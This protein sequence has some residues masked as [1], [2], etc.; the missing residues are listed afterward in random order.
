MK[1]F[2]ILFTGNVGSSPLLNCLKTSPQAFI[3]LYEHLDKRHW[4][5]LPLDES[6]RNTFFRKIFKFFLHPSNQSCIELESLFSSIRQV[7]L[8]KEIRDCANLL[9]ASDDHTLAGFKWRP[10]E[11]SGIS[12][13]FFSNL[14]ARLSVVPIVPLRQNLISALLRPYFNNSYA[15]KYLSNETT[16][17]LQF[18]FTKSK[19][20]NEDYEMH[21]EQMRSHSFK[22]SDDDFEN[23]LQK[24]TTYL[25]E[26]RRVLEYSCNFDARPLYICTESITENPYCQ[27]NKI[28]DTFGLNRIPINGDIFFRKAGMFSDDQVENIDQLLSHTGISDLANL[29]S[30]L[31]SELPY[32]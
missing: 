8:P 26:T 32:L 23:I 28:L 5:N 30:E 27:A 20:S 18:H 4:I 11:P 19:M 7:P 2:I 17:H 13:K 29:Y 9:N 3:R 21:L 10:W 12:L 24:A 6:E 14:Y 31:V 15:R 25:K 22:L 1:S 16:V